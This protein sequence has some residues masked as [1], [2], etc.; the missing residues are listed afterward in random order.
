MAVLF[1]FPFLPPVPPKS[2]LS[3]PSVSPH[4]FQIGSLF[5]PNYYCYKYT[6]MYMCGKIYKRNLLSPFVLLCVYVVWGLT[7]TG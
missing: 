3:S 7:L 1:S 6:Y 5:F 2:F 4:H